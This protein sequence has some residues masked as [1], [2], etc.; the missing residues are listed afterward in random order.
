MFHFNIG[1]EVGLN[2]FTL[3]FSKKKKKH[4]YDAIDL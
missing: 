4:F 3:L 2:T 1:I